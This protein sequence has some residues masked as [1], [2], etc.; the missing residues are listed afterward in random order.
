MSYDLE[1]KEVRKGLHVERYG[2]HVRGGRMGR[3]VS[4]CTPESTKTLQIRSKIPWNRG[5]V[6]GSMT[7]NNFQVVLTDF[8]S[9][10][11]VLLK[12]GLAKEYLDNPATGQ[13]GGIKSKFEKI[14]A[15]SLTSIIPRRG[16]S[17]EGSTVIIWGFKFHVKISWK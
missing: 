16:R 17:I 6:Q 9:C 1:V 10:N 13:S 3:K 11:N 2:L 4:R 14:L 7:S 15:S 8:D 12:Y 5:R